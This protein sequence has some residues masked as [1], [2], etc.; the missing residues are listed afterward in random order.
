MIVWLIFARSLVI[1]LGHNRTD[2]TGHQSDF[3]GFSHLFSIYQSISCREMKKE[4][5]EREIGFKHANTTQG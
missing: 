2:R 3:T 5:M 4:L 1:K